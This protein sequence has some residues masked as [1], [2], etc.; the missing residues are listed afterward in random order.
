M[1][2]RCACHGS[3]E[4]AA[5]TRTARTWHT[6]S[7]QRY[8]AGKRAGRGQWRAQDRRPGAWAAAERADNGGIFKGAE[9]CG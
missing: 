2:R 9:P 8:Q 5:L 3:R 6:P 4:H 7:T 1:P